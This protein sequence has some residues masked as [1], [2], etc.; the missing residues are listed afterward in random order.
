MNN[1]DSI[2]NDYQTVYKQVNVTLELLLITLR[3]MGL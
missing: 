2:G 1:C 3:S